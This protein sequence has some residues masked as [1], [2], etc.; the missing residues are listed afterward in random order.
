MAVFFGF[1]TG[2]ECIFIWRMKDY[3]SHKIVHWSL[4]HRLRIAYWIQDLVWRNFRIHRFLHFQRGEWILE[5]CVCMVGANT[6]K[7]NFPNFF[8]FSLFIFIFKIYELIYY[9]LWELVILKH[10][11]YL[12]Q[13]EGISHLP[14]PAKVMLL[15]LHAAR[16]EF[17]DYCNLLEL[18]ISAIYNLLIY[19]AG[20]GGAEYARGKGIPVILFPKAKDEPEALS[21][22]DLVAALRFL[23]EY[24]SSCLVSFP[25]NFLS[26]SEPN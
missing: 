13:A 20:C 16:M 24:Y 14:L 23:F 17:R 10:T 19:G 15:T 6:K 9:V 12:A 7:T 26:L 3:E 21:P 4:V 1:H 11:S 18:C 2:F 22:N 8:I 5:N 25:C